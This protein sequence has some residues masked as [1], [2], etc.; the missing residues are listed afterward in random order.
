MNYKLTTLRTRQQE[1]TMYV[2]RKG[3]LY[4]RDLIKLICL[5]RPIQLHLVLS[6]ILFWAVHMGSTI[7]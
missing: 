6:V 3:V 2:P 1:K 4:W 7:N 5:P